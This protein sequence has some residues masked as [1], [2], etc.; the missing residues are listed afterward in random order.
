[1]YRPVLPCVKDI[2]NI[3]AKSSQLLPDVKIDSA[4][5]NKKIATSENN[6]DFIIVPN[7]IDDEST[8][9]SPSP[10]EDD[11]WNDKITHSSMHQ[12]RKEAAILKDSNGTQLSYDELKIKAYSIAMVQPPKC[13]PSSTTSHDACDGISVLSRD[14]LWRIVTLEDSNPQ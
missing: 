2:R 12:N 13:L 14:D 4:R 3:F 9:L 8:S 10:T 7:D 1:M 11:C 5:Q 6:A